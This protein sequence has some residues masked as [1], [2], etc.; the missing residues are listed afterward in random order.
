MRAKLTKSCV[1][2]AVK[3]E[4]PDRVPVAAVHDDMARFCDGE[5]WFVFFDSEESAPERIVFDAV[6]Q[7]DDDGSVAYVRAT[8]RRKVPA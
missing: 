6:N 2:T 1:V 7:Y 4:M 8:I 5:A 3:N